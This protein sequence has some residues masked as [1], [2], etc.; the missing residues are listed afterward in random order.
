M[1]WAVEQRIVLG[2]RRS[3]NG[4]NEIEAGAVKREEGVVDNLALMQQLGR[5]PGRPDSE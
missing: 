1:A 4:S 3:E 5:S 2:K